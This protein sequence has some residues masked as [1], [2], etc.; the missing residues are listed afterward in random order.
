[1]PEFVVLV[2]ENDEELGTQ[3]KMAAHEEGN[4]HRALS[5][6]IFNS[7]GKYLL[8]RRALSKYHSGGLWTNACCSH[9]RQGEP[10]M[11]AALRRLQEEMGFSCDLKKVFD[12]VYKADVGGGLTEHEYDHVFIGT[13]DGPIELNPDEVD[14]YKWV[15]KEELLRDVEDNPQHY[16]EWFKIMLRDNVDKINPLD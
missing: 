8:H 7:D 12:F 6:H 13:H 16:T 11:E 1:M 2:S 15:S 14:S 3:E 10:P 9:P 4:L 5:V